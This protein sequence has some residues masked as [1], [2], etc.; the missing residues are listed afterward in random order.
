MEETGHAYPCISM[1]GL[2]KTRKIFRK[3]NRFTG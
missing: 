2:R 3:E 1:E